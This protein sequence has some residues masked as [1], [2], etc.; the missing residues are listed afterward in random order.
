MDLSININM[1]QHLGHYIVD[2]KFYY[3]KSHASNTN[4]HIFSKDYTFKKQWWEFDISGLIIKLIK[5][6]CNLIVYYSLVIG[7]YLL[8]NISKLL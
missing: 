2:G 4:H 6:K 3:S 8:L 7:F 5:V 1:E